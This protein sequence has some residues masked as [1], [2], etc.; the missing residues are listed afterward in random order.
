MIIL[1]SCRLQKLKGLLLT[2]ARISVRL[3][4]FPKPLYCFYERFLTEVAI[5]VS[6]KEAQYLFH[7]HIP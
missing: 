2:L 1:R 5:L 3:L 6:I 4:K 7:Q